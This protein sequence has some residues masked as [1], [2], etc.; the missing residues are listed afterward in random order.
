MSRVKWLCNASYT[1]LSCYA[2][3]MLVTNAHQCSDIRLKGKLNIPTMRQCLLMQLL[4][5][6]NHS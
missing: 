2:V 1:Q 4:A 5:I 3:M 6:T